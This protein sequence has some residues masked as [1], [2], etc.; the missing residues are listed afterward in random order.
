MGIK[1]ER[2]VTVRTG[3]KHRFKPKEF[4]HTSSGPSGTK[5]R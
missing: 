2:F 1:E 5:G 4:E 3:W